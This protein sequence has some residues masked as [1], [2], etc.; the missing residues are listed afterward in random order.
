M[1]V[2]SQG[3]QRVELSLW[4][5]VRESTNKNIGWRHII[6]KRKR[7]GT[8]NLASERLLVAWRSKGMHK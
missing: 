7:V 6:F 3:D 1:Q 4:I 5:Q 8:C 2:A